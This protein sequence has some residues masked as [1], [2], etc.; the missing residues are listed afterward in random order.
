MAN[1]RACLTT[2]KYVGGGVLGKR[3]LRKA[4]IGRVVPVTA[5]TH[6]KKN[7]QRGPTV[8]N[9]VKTRVAKPPQPMTNNKKAA[10]MKLAT[11]GE[12]FDFILR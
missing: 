12:R 6:R 7:N 1:Q 8:G 2:A 3:R 5:K 10:G 4:V 9:V 11:R